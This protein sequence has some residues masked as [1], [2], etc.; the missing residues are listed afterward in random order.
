MLEHSLRAFLS[1]SDCIAICVAVAPDD[2]RWPEVA[3]RLANTRLQSV[4]GG[5]ERAHSVRRGLQGLELALGPA[6]WV[7]VH[8]AARPCVTRAEI[9]ALKLAVAEHP[10][11]GLLAVPL[12]DTLKRALAA[13]S[14]PTV[15]ATLP[16]DGLWRALTPQAFRFGLLR[17]ALD[18][19]LAANRVPTD[20]AQA[21][22]WRGGQPLLVTGS[23]ENIKVTTPSDL[24][25]AEALLARRTP[26]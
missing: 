11:G 19:A 22:E 1:D 23:T 10:V 18:A 9:D 12:A 25:L 15:D 7:L 6:D 2:E 4:E 16:R 21:I 14:V 5:A 24:H 17:D 3:A 8:D 20:E 26:G 13:T